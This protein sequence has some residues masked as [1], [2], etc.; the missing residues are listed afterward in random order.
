[1]V[2]VGEG[3]VQLS[4]G[5]RARIGLARALYRGSI[6]GGKVM[7]VDG[8]MSA[9]DARVGREVMDKAIKGP[10]CEDK[11]VIMITYDLD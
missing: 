7:L 11:I 1:M 3:G 4:G 5:Q 8:V 9:L 10:L 2:E 6:S